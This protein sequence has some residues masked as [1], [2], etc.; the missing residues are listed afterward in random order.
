M[1]PQELRSQLEAVLAEELGAESQMYRDAIAV[2]DLNH[3]RGGPSHGIPE[4]YAKYWQPFQTG[5]TLYHITTRQNVQSIKRHGLEPRDPFPRPWAGMKAV[6]LADPAE[7]AFESAKPH[8]VAHVREK[9]EEPVLLKIRT[10]NRL[11]KSAGP[12]RLF[13]VISLDPVPAGDIV[14][15]QPLEP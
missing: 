2:F 14:G 7:P 5:Q 6:Y 10:N 1:T 8:V 3:R 9:G 12:T 11:F 13:Q 4:P 15:E